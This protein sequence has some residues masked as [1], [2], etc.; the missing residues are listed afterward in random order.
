LSISKIVSISVIAL[1]GVIAA[2]GL[3][4]KS[5]KN[6]PVLD[7]SK[8]LAQEVSIEKVEKKVVQE[9][10]KIKDKTIV[11]TAKKE[12]EQNIVKVDE[13]DLPQADIIN[14]L[15]VTDSTKL[16]IVETISYT[17][18][19]PWLNGKQAWIADYASHYSTTRHFIAR[20]LN[21]KL[22]Y[23]TQKVSYGD[24]FNVLRDD[25]NLKFHL[26]IDVNKSKLWFYYVDIDKNERVLLKTYDVGLGRKD[27]KKE[28]GLLTPL[29]KYSLGSK[30]AIYKPKVMG[31]FQDN[32]IE[33][34]KVF[35]TRWIPFDQELANCTE[36]S[37]G[38]G[39]HGAPWIE[40]NNEF[41]EDRSKIGAYDSDGCIRLFSE[42]IEELFAIIISRPTEIELV[43][44]F[45][46]IKFKEDIKLIK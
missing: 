35:G 31:Y 41:Q 46:D 11:K 21:K 10:P 9:K 27:D 43:K 19:V 30:V 28:S 25:I 20:S 22:D 15:F 23:F 2:L 5:K 4:K 3:L 33:M 14:R 7:A 32:K 1:F 42:D 34:I 29:G 39:I 17:S 12:K 26:V 37:K 13:N 6:D 8:P 38:L 44:D 40:K 36:T 24:R 18:R 45:H 16:P